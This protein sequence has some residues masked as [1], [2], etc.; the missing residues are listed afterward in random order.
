M[1]I[2]PVL[3]LVAIGDS[4][5]GMTASDISR[6]PLTAHSINAP[7]ASGDLIVEQRRFTNWSP[8]RELVGRVSSQRRGSDSLC[9]QKT[10]QIKPAAL[11]SR[12]GFLQPD[13]GKRRQALRQVN[14]DKFMGWLL[15]TGLSIFNRVRCSRFKIP[16]SSVTSKEFLRFR[17]IIWLRA[18]GQ[19]PCHG[20]KL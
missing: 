19:P 13:R 20:V 18:E 3:F 12:C 14:F 1:R 16:V 6:H 5:E 11:I 4:H 17:S 10:L 15:P 9:R 8:R 2:N 7:L